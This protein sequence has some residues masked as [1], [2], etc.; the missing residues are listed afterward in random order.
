MGVR[1]EFVCAF[2]WPVEANTFRHKAVTKHMRSIQPHFD[3][4]ALLLKRLAFF[5]HDDCSP[6]DVNRI[7]NFYGIACKKLGPKFVTTHL[8]TITNH[9]CSASRFGLPRQ[10][11]VFC[12]SKND[13]CNDRIFHSLSCPVIQS[14][15]AK[16]HSLVFFDIQVRDCLLLIDGMISASESRVFHYMYFVIVVFHVYNA[17]RKGTV[18]SDR[19]LTFSI[20]KIVKNSPKAWKLRREIQEHGF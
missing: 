6:D 15:F 11:C 9:W 12:L 7:V 18:F 3:F 16:H 1:F 19:L 17:C 20:K 8:R 14:A 2:C 13:D 4:K 10:A 5:F